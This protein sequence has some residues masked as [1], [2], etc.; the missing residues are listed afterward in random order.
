[1]Y[2]RWCFGAYGHLPV[3]L[4]HGDDDVE[5]RGWLRR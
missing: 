3:N 2:F 4:C 5:L 1:L